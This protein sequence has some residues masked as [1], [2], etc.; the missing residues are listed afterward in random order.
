MELFFKER[1]GNMS[2][3]GSLA[4]LLSNGAEFRLSHPWGMMMRSLNRLFLAHQPRGENTLWGCP[5]FPQEAQADSFPTSSRAALQ[6]L[7]GQNR[8]SPTLALQQGVR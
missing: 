6:L 3:R 1:S 4:L 7:I 2:Q 5:Q 8:S